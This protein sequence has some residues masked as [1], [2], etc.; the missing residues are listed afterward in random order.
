MGRSVGL[1][2]CLGSKLAG[3]AGRGKGSGLLVGSLIDDVYHVVFVAETPPEDDE[4]VPEE[5]KPESLT[6]RNLDVEWMV[7]HA[8]QVL[9][10]LPGGLTVLGIFFPCTD[11]F[12]TTNDGK[13]RK[14]F[15]TIM[16]LDVSVPAELLI[17]Q[18]A[19]MTKVLD[20]KTNSFKA[21]EVKTRPRPVEFVKLESQLVLDIPLAIQPE[22]N[23]LECLED[24]VK[25]ILVKFTQQLDNSRFVFNNKVMSD[26][27]VIGKA[28]E[29]DKKKGKGKI[30][31]KPVEEEEEQE[32]EVIHVELLATETVVEDV[33]VEENTVARMKVAGKLSCRA[34]LPPGAN[35]A[36]ARR[37][38]VRDLTRSLGTRLYMHTE[39]LDKEAEE[40]DKIVHEPPRRVFVNVPDTCVTV[41]D[42]LYPTEGVEDCTNNIREIFGWE[43]LEDSVEDD[44]EIVAS[45]RETR[46]MTS[47]GKQKM[48]ARRKLPVGYFLGLGVGLISMG[49]A[50]LSL[51][52]GN[53]ADGE[54][55]M[56]DEL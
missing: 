16:N 33:V 52:G 43:L 19:L 44:V 11:S 53:E 28:H 26:D 1:E 7:E 27:D 12:L 5:E 6:D 18:S 54:D 21:V 56:E 42:Y 45:P 30:S 41:C 55:G 24:D 9:R 23:N 36:W 35:V 2:P 38:V 4:E 29:V 31:N 15:Q 46:P 47:D 8:K 32:Q 25:E 13:V 48:E 14:C 3:I 39:T 17:L 40:E 50:W 34:Y 10:L 49:L 37:A 51:R 22:S 20:S